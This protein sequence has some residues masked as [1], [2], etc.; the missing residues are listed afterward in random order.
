A[1][2]KGTNG[3][4][5]K[6]EKLLQHLTAEKACAPKISRWHA[7]SKDCGGSFATD[8]CAMK[9]GLCPQCPESDGWPSEHRPSRW[10]ASGPE[11]PQQM[12]P[13]QPRPIGGEADHPSRWARSRRDLKREDA[14]IEGWGHSVRSCPR[15]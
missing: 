6:I 12:R 13:P 10:A 1:R 15:R 3:R 4:N 5:S 11:Q 2:R 9:S 8:R 14:S 7:N